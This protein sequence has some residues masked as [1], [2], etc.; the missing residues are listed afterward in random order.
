MIHD[1]T[2]R[3][4]LVAALVLGSA[5][6]A[7]AQTEGRIGVGGTVTLNHT[8][9]SDV[10]TAVTIGPL[11][12][13]NPKPG[14]HFAGGFNWWLADLEHPAG[15]DEPF[16][17]LTVKPFMGGIGYTLGPPR[18]LV[19]FSV[20]AGPSFNRARFKD[21]FGDANGGASIEAKTSF[22]IRPGIS[23]TQT[24]APRVGLTGF[25]GYMVNRPKIVYRS[26]TGQEIDD[27]W[28]ADAL[29]LSIGLVYSVF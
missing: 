20:V 5:L 3:I 24:L 13:L 6:T 11:V 27:R 22:V 4:A 1:R 17:R 15:G 9:D 18:T 28:T 7:R 16:A 21:D 25:A 23:V 10:D 8:I 2:I 14:W 26:V 19:N 29:V 12:R